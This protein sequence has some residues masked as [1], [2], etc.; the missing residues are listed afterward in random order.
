M[1]KKLFKVLFGFCIFAIG[2]TVNA[3]TSTDL[4]ELPDGEGSTTGTVTVGDVSTPIYNVNIYWDDLTFDWAYDDTVGD[5]AWKPSNVCREFMSYGENTNLGAILYD[6]STCSNPVGNYEGGEHDGT[7]KYYKVSRDV[8]FFSIEDYSEN[9]QVIPS[10]KWNSAEN[11]EYVN[12]EFT[13]DDEAC[14]L[15][16]NENVY[17]TA[18]N[19]GVYS[20][21]SCTNK[22]ETAPFEENKYYALVANRRVLESEELPDSARRSAAGSAETVEGYQFIVNAYTRNHYYLQI[23]LVNDEIPSELPQAGDQIGTI[24]IS[25]KAK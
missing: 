15:I 7:D 13:I 14:V 25:I 6:D 3:E 9:G 18:V 24:T 20:D 10:V 23:D 17:G 19:Y 8:V 1:K 11:Y 2:L 21:N 12:A 16:P 5:Y 22:V 4:P